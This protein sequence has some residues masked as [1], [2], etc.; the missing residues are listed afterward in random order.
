MA[1]SVQT[2]ERTAGRGQNDAADVLVAA[3]AER[4]E[5]GIVLGIDRQHAGAGGGGGAHEHGAG[6][7]QAF[8]VG[9][10][11]R[12][13]ALGRRRAWAAIRPIR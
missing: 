7:H 9:Q 4:L 8:L 10:R 3:G 12:G 6:A 1:S 5:N 2:A 13:A 11:D